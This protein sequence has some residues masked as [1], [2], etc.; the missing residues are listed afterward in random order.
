MSCRRKH[1]PFSAVAVTVLLLPACDSQPSAEFR[2]VTSAD[3]ADDEALQPQSQPQEPVPGARLG[4]V[5]EHASQH[6]EI[7]REAVTAEL[8]SPEDDRE[9][10]SPAALS[11]LIPEPVFVQEGPGQALRVSFDDFDLQRVLGVVIPQP[12]VISHLP[13]WL[14]ALNGQR[15]RVRGYM[16]PAWREEDLTGFVLAR[17][18][19]VCCFGPRG[20]IY[21]LVTVKLRRGETTDYI[22]LRPFDVEGV[23]RI[24]PVADG[25][26]MLQLYLIDDAVM[27]N[28]H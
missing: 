25:D 8:T 28:H 14:R 3:V 1:R 20:K 10:I 27:M 23:S 9:S 13:G 2:T 16:V 18:T 15:V 6:V 12:E 26:E 17:D 22:Q 4:Y 7:D 5:S 24:Q 19:E 11:P 21:H